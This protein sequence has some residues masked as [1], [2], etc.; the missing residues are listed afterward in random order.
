[1]RVAG[2]SKHV[3]VEPIAPAVIAASIFHAR[4]PRPNR[5]N[6]LLGILLHPPPKL[7]GHAPL[8]HPKPYSQFCLPLEVGAFGYSKLADLSLDSPCQTS[9]KMRPAITRHTR[10]KTFVLGYVSIS[11][12]TGIPMNLD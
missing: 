11:P 3:G 5:L 9:M 8:T 10:T 4:H 1:M 2:E 12:L 7:P 6:L